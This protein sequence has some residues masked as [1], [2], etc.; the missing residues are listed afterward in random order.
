M[1]DQG[2]Y[3]EIAEMCREILDTEEPF[4]WNYDLSRHE[5]DLTIDLLLRTVLG[6]TEKTNDGTFSVGYASNKFNGAYNK[7]T[8][9]KVYPY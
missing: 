7:L 5:K 2:R 6:L 9:K 3:D 4:Y 8:K 1:S